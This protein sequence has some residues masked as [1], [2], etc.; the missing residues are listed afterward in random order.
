[1]IAKE[2]SEHAINNFPNNFPASIIQMT[3]EWLFIIFLSHHLALNTSFT[4]YSLCDLFPSYLHCMGE[5]LIIFYYN[6]KLI[7]DSHRLSL[8]LLFPLKGL[9]LLKLRSILEKLGISQDD[10]INELTIKIFRSHIFSC[11]F[12][13]DYRIFFTASLKN[14]FIYQ[15]ITIRK[16]FFINFFTFLFS[17]TRNAPVD[18]TTVCNRVSFMLRITFEFIMTFSLS[19]WTTTYDTWARRSFYESKFLFWRYSWAKRSV[20]GLRNFSLVQREIRNFSVCRRSNKCFN[21]NLIKEL[22]RGREQKICH[23]Q[24]NE[25]ESVT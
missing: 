2:N 18:S 22:E 4:W 5:G 1:M 15:V 10:K 3:P 8:A 6:L 12:F 24:K 23:E 25:Q 20:Y 11:S 14:N 21:R 19:L 7:N 17:P 13:S 9:W 16:F